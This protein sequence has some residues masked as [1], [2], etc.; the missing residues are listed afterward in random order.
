ME[1]RSY[2]Q[3]SLNDIIFEGRNQAYGAYALRQAYPKHLVKAI[4]YMIGW[5]ALFLAGAHLGLPF[6]SDQLHPTVPVSKIIKIQT[7]VLPVTEEPIVE[8]PVTRQSPVTPVSPTRRS[9]SAR[10]V[11][12]KTLIT[13]NNTSQADLIDQEP[14]LTDVAVNPT[15]GILPADVSGNGS[16]LGSDEGHTVRDFVEQM[17]E[18]PGGTAQMYRFIRENLRYPAVAQREGL[19]GVVV[20]TFVVGINGE[21]ADIQVVKDIGGGTAEE[22]VR[23]IRKMKNWKPGVK[24]GKPVPVR[25][26]MPLRFSLAS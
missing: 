23:V 14:G 16:A 22:A 24:N 18:F 20:V 21:I 7:V 17:P 19:T 26:T 13:E 4:F 8:R 15:T 3:Y 5:V 2:A 25:F 11:P 12:D 10:I 6:L 1:T 9:V